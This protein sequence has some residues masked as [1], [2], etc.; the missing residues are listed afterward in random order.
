VLNVELVCGSVD[1]GD[2]VADTGFISGVDPQPIGTEFALDVE[3]SFVKPEIMPEYE[4]TF[5]DERAEDSARKYN[6]W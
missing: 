2:D 5:G 1:V 3:L 4:A 6:G